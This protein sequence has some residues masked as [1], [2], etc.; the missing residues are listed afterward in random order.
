MFYSSV[1]LN[2]TETPTD[3]VRW[4]TMFYSSVILNST[5][6]IDPYNLF[7]DLF[8]SSVILNSTETKLRRTVA[9]REVLQ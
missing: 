5:E 2:S 4:R 7:K 6:T 3:R 9:T 8:Y 1:I